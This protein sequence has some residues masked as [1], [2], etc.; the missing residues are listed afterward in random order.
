MFAV[1]TTLKAKRAT[2]ENRKRRF[3]G[4]TPCDKDPMGK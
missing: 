3:M 2:A 4:V 1:A